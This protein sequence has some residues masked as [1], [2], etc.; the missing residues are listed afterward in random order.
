MYIDLICDTAMES[1]KT[2]ERGKQKTNIWTGVSIR[3]NTVTV[4]T[5]THKPNI[6]THL[7]IFCALQC[8]VIQIE[9]CSKCRFFKN[10]HRSIINVACVDD[11]KVACL[12]PFTASLAM[13]IHTHAYSISIVDVTYVLLIFLQCEWWK[14]TKI[15]KL[16]EFCILQR[17]KKGKKKKKNERKNEATNWKSN[18]FCKQFANSIWISMCS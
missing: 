9:I 14:S 11:S 1:R 5:H 15:F 2:R 10:A 6:N 4:I 8:D 18:T 3:R 12:C 16:L 17:N 7:S 13:F